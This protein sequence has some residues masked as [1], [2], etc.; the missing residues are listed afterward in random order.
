VLGQEAGS[1]QAHARSEGRKTKEEE[2]ETKPVSSRM[3]LFERAVV[4][5]TGKVQLTSQYLEAGVASIKG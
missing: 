4:V 3:M 1:L 5:S 2:I